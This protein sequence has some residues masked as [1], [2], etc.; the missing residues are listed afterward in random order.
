MYDGQQLAD[1]ALIKR[2][3][4]NMYNK[5]KKVGELRERED[6]QIGNPSSGQSTPDRAIALM[7]S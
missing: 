2:N 3:S 4:Y 5:T 1:W 7:T 6:P